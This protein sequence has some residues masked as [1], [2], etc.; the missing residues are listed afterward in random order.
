MQSG[1]F[2]AL[3][4]ISKLMNILQK[5]FQSELIEFPTYY[6]SEFNFQNL[7]NSP[8]RMF[9]PSEE[10]AHTQFDTTWNRAIRI[11]TE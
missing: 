11:K 5:V 8:C 3:A 10:C 7:Y 6:I 9:T 2:N 1:K 4:S